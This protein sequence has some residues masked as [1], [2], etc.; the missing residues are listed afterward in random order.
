MTLDFRDLT[1]KQTIIIALA[2][3]FLFYLAYQSRERLTTSFMGKGWNTGEPLEARQYTCQNIQAGVTRMRL[4]DSGD[5][6]KMHTQPSGSW[7]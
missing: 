3:V 2:G 5:L 7:Q 4:N 6:V 1:T